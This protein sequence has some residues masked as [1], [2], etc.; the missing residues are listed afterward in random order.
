MSGEKSY[1]EEKQRSVDS[2]AEA[3]KRAGSVS[4]W[5]ARDDEPIPGDPR[6]GDPWYDAKV[7]A[8]QVVKALMLQ[9]EFHSMGP[10]DIF[11]A[12]ELAALNL[13]NDTNCPLSDEQKKAARKAAYDYY[14][15]ARA[16]IP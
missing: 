5:T 2:L 8:E 4:A 1:V 11:F 7:V 16:K 10:K 9:A 12:M 13:F 3:Y 6:N 14:V 15:S